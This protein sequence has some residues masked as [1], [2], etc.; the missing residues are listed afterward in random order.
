MKKY[1]FLLLLC[2]MSITSKA[3][4]AV[5]TSGETVVFS[6]NNVAIPIFRSDKRVLKKLDATSFQIV[7]DAKVNTVVKKADIT[8]IL[9]ASVSGNSIEEIII[10]I[11]NVFEAVPIISK[12][13]LRHR[14]Q[15]YRCRTLP[16][17]QRG[18]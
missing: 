16:A 17:P 14:L 5:S 4:F 7:V 2:V 11:N 10:L 13:P 8:T 12:V 6:I 18:R 1:L 9:G 15:R 3:Q